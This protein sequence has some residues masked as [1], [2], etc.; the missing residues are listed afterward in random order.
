MERGGAGADGEN[1]VPDLGE[2]SDD[3][4][5]VVRWIELKETVEKF[6]EIVFGVNLVLEYHLEHGVSEVQVRVVG[7]F[8][9]RHALAPHTAEPPHALGVVAELRGR[10]DMARREGCGG[11][12]GT[13]GGGGSSVVSVLRPV[14]GLGSEGGPLG[15]TFGVEYVTE[16]LGPSAGAAAQADGDSVEG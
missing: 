6:S 7:V 13:G 9:H 16:K 2:G 3:D 1:A 11:G 8:F 12:C 15:A 5:V 4:A 10:V 14:M